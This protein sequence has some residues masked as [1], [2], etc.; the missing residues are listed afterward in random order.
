MFEFNRKKNYLLKHEVGSGSEPVTM[1]PG[2]M[3]FGVNN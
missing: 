2:T 3:L 1:I